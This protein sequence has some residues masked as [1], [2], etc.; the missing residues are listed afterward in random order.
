V[1]KDLLHRPDS[2]VDPGGA[3]VVVGLVHRYHEK[4]WDLPRTPSVMIASVMI[5]SVMIVSQGVES[6]NDIQHWHL[7]ARHAP[8]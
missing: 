1:R 2:R 4:S 7:A 6:D 5:A 3:D 8:E